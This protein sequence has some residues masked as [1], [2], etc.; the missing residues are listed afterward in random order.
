V[1]P[2]SLRSL[3]DELPGPRHSAPGRLS[4]AARPGD[5]GAGTCSRPCSAALPIWSRARHSRTRS[6]V[7]P[8]HAA[9]AEAALFLLRR[10]VTSA[11]LRPCPA[12]PHLPHHRATIAPPSGLIS[13]RGLPTRWL[14]CSASTTSILARSRCACGGTCISRAAH[15]VMPRTRRRC[16]PTKRARPPIGGSGDISPESGRLWF[17][18]TCGCPDSPFPPGLVIWMT[19]R[20]GHLGV[21]SSDHQQRSLGVGD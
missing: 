5:A 6:G 2:S 21:A 7:I 3:P 9:A 19:D 18:T 10:R 8:A 15:R 12:N 11:M 16:P 14:S 13:R 17:G 20:E 4:Q 1:P